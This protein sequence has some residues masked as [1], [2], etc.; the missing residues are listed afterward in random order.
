MKLYLILL[1]TFNQPEQNPSLETIKR[2]VI[3]MRALAISL[4]DRLEQ[5]LMVLENNIN[6]LQAVSD[7]SHLKRVQFE[8]SRIQYGFALIWKCIK[9]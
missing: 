5:D 2:I 1:L 7:S 6:Q 3:D 4:P 8:F 9:K